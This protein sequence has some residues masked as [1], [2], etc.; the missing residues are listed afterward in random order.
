MKA[1]L[2]IKKNKLMTI[3]LAI[4]MLL[5]TVIMLPQTIKAS[6]DNKI[7][8]SKTSGLTCGETIW[9]N[10]TDGGLIENTR[11]Y[12][13]IWNGIDWENIADEKADSDGNIA[14]QMNIPYR[15]PL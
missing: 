5:S 12:V 14:I 7:D 8:V 10:V 11:Y 1:N 13:H 4:L 15:N 3:T 9:V 6:P 2:T